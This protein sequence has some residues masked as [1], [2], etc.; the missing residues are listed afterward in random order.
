MNMTRHNTL[1]RRS[2]LATG[3]AFGI[4]G[5]AFGK[6]RARQ[7]AAGAKIRLA[8]IGCDNQ[9]TGLIQRMGGDGN[10]EIVAMCDPYNVQFDRVK[11]AAVKFHGRF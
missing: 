7:V 5:A 8:L 11:A 2:F 4:G 1:S 6:S 3:A 10:V 9:M